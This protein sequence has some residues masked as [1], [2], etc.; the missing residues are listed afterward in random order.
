[1]VCITYRFYLGQ[2]A[3]AFVCSSGRLS[4]FM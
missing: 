3:A 2:R 1:M 4:V